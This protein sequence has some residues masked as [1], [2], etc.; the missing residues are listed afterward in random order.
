MFTACRQN[1]RPLWMLQPFLWWVQAGWKGTNLA[2]YETD[3]Y[4]NIVSETPELRQVYGAGEMFLDG[5]HTALY[6]EYVSNLVVYFV[7]ISG[8]GTLN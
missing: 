2:A 8:I 5:I 4:H 6:V 1:V 7:E 3:F